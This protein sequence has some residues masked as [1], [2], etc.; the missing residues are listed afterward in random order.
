MYFI[1]SVKICNCNDINDFNYLLNIF[2][3]KFKQK[4]F[5]FSIYF[6]F[7]FLIFHNINKD[8]RLK[9]EYK[10]ILNIIDKDTDKVIA[11]NNITNIADNNITNIAD[12][13]LINKITTGRMN[14]W[15][16]NLYYIRNNNFLIFGKGVQID[17]KLLSMSSSNAFIYSWLSG[18]LVSAILYI[19]L[20]IFYISSQK[21]VLIKFLTKKIIK[22]EIL[23]MNTIIFILFCR[24]LVENSFLTIQIDLM[25]IVFA[26]YAQNFLSYKKNKFPRVNK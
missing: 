25:L 21:K 22:K 23:L 5:S 3:N 2:K 16:Q 18:G 26:F 24:S 19:I 11:D 7:P 8:Y 4:N 6:F 9:I 13:S 20:I 15:V 17:K 1:S 12:N 14:I 10:E